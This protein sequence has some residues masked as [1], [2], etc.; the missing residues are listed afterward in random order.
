M[1]LEYPFLTGTRSQA[2]DQPAIAGERQQ[3]VDLLHGKHY[4][5]CL[6]G[7]VFSQSATP[8]GLAIPIYTATAIAGGMPILNPASSPVNVEL[9]SVDIN[10]GSGTADF[11]AVGLMAGF[12]TGIGTATGCSALAATQAV[13][14]NLGLS[15]G[16]KVIS[17][18][19]GTVT[20]TAGT[21]AAPVQGVAGAGWVRSLA[22]INL[23][24]DTG[25]AHTTSVSHFDFDGTVIVPPGMIVYLACTKASVA[26]YASS[27]VWKEIPILN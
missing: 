24:A 25:T 23:E 21:A 26:L 7:R 4:V 10:R 3:V 18:N 27:I 11:G 22:C 1:Y 15:G 9:I 6:R 16:S 20:V 13:C 8:L 5:D 12:C 19:A 17:S 14:G 2:S